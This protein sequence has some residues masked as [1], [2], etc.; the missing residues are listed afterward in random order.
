[1]ARTGRPREFDKEQTLERAL[2]LFWSR[3]Y[4]ATSIQDLVDALSVERGSL[5]GTFGDKRRFY[6]EAVRLYWEVYE[7]RLIATLDTSPLLPALRE[8]LTHPAR[9]DEFI[10]DVGVPQGCL[11]GNTTAE[12][13]PQDAEAT[14]I[15]A[16]SYSRFTEIVTA[17]LERAQAAGEVTDKARPEA[18]ASM[19]LYLVQGLSLVSRAGLDRTAALAA[20]DTAVDGLRA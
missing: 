9:L 1:M 18:Q 6:L 20:I 19:L 3:G 7:R 11:V 13:V 12:L 2:K 5:Y 16:R 10:S 4:G 17:A 15:V 14:E 8:I